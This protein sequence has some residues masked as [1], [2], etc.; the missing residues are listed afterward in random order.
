MKV[1]ERTLG[2]VLD[3]YD[4]IR[5]PLSSLERETRQGEYRYYGAQGVIDHINEYLFD[6]EFILIAED[7]ANLV[8]RKEPIAFFVDGQFWVNNH[9]HVVRGKEYVADSFYIAALL[10]N[11]NI[12][13]YI[14]G[15]AQ[16]KLSQQNLK[17]IKVQLP[18]YNGQRCIADILSAYDDLIENNRRRMALLE[19][20][21]RLLYREWFVRLRFPGH[22]HT[23]IINGV[24]DAWERTAFEHALV[25]QRGFDLPIQAREDGDVPSYASTGINGFHS[26]AKVLGPGVVTGRSGTLGEVHYVAG[27]FWPL[28][29][30]RWGKEFKRVTPLFSLFLMREMDLKQYNGGVSVPTLD[31]KT[32]H[33][34]EVLIPPKNLLAAFDEFVIPLFEQI[35]NLTLQNQKLKQARDLLLPKLM[36]GEIAV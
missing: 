3:F 17:Q 14:T 35:G 18:S 15:A 28:N 20:S 2:D 5:V 13:G 33:R 11:L 7:G 32:V 6:G 12:A 19:E 9:A 21:A 24:P 1:E 34:V 22:E 30:A 26:K 27:D 10:N 29:T 31:R 16:P 36:S 8:T 23:H 4:H 25:L